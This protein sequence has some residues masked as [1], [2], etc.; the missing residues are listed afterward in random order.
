MDWSIALKI[1]HLSFS[2]EQVT[3]PSMQ[4]EHVQCGSQFLDCRSCSLLNPQHLTQCQLINIWWMGAL[5]GALLWGRTWVGRAPSL[6]FS[7]LFA[8]LLSDLFPHPGCCHL[9]PSQLL[10]SFGVQYMLLVWL[11][12]ISLF[13]PS[14]VGS[15][16][17][18][19]TIFYSY[20][21]NPGSGRG[22]PKVPVPGPPGTS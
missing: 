15:L 6:S 13:C 2:E 8:L 12:F 4:P 7:R 20:R 17:K 22:R 16:L 21:K 11:A 5:S 14:W 1:N 18:A 9:R 19:S 3:T 10:C